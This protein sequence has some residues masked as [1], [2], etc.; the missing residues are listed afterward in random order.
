MIKAL[1]LPWR[2]VVGI[3]HLFDLHRLITNHLAH[4]HKEI[5]NPT[6]YRIEGKVDVMLR[7]RG[8][9]YKE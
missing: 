6:L 4:D 9:K 8:L 5:L 7:D 3:V 2:A 1:C